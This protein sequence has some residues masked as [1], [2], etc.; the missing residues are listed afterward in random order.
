MVQIDPDLCISFK[1]T[2]VSFKEYHVCESIL[3][4]QD[5]IHE[6]LIPPLVEFSNFIYWLMFL[7]SVGIMLRNIKGEWEREWLSH[8]ARSEALIHY[9]FVTNHPNY[10]RYASVPLRHVGASWV[11]I[12]TF[13][14]RSVA[15]RQCDSQF[16][17][18]WSDLGTEKTTLSKLQAP[19]V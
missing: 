11:D 3:N 7:E 19:V 16:N 9:I 15:V 10:S 18:I 4:L 1:Q 5:K 8:L 13:H 12:R 17:G 2:Q 14:R 6:S